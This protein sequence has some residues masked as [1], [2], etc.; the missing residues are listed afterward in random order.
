MTPEITK[1]GPWPAVTLQTG[2]LVVE[3]HL[4]IAPSIV[5]GQI[6]AATITLQG[7]GSPAVTGRLDAT[8]ARRAA[9]VLEALAD[10]MEAE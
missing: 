7:R 6:E 3:G 8:A 2:L 4:A 9:A 10:A 1:D 5:E